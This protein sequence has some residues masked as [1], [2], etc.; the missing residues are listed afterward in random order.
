MNMKQQLMVD[1]F[2]DKRLFNPNVGRMTFIVSN[3]KK[4]AVR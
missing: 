3:N 2:T 1:C 4:M